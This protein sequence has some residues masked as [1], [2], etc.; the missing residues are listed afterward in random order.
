MQL[1]GLRLAGTD[2]KRGLAEHDRLL[3]QPVVSLSEPLAA[4]AQLSEMAAA[5]FRP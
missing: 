4:T 3:V 2:R 1:D 5:L